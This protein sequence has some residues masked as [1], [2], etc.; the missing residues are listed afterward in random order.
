MIGA[1]LVLVVGAVLLGGAWSFRQQ[2]KQLWLVILM[3]V[4]GVLCVVV[5]FWRINQ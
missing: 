4:L 5:A 1:F 2:R 3:A